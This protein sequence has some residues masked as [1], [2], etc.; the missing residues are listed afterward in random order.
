MNA[1]GL[2]DRLAGCWRFVRELAT[3]DAYERY[4]AH[5]RSTHGASPPLDRRAFYLLEQH[6]KWSDIKRCC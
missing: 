6:R 4:L 3:D 2:R 5:H 1:S